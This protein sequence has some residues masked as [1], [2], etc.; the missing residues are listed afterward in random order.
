MYS[1]PSNRQKT[2]FDQFYWPKNFVY[3]TVA[4]LGQD[5]DNIDA[6]VSGNFL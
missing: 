3:I 1:F 4:S 5:N 2:S 6:I